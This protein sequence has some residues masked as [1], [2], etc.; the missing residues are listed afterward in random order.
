MLVILFY[1]NVQMYLI[2]S[3]KKNESI[4]DSNEE[5]TISPISRNPFK[6]VR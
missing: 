5:S 4:K 6:R 3:G 1:Y 2:I